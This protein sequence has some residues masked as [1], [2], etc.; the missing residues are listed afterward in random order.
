MSCCNDDG[1]Q[2]TICTWR[3]ND[4]C[5]FRR[6]HCIVSV[7]ISLTFKFMFIVAIIYYMM[8]D[9]PSLGNIL[10]LISM[11]FSGFCDVEQTL[12]YYTLNIL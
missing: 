3:L 6:L 10:V 1:Q 9:V 8:I 4:P 11:S 2:S 12:T 7:K 5:G